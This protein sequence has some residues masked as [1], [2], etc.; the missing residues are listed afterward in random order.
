MS[1]ISAV[2]GGTT[3]RKLQLVAAIESR[4]AKYIFNDFIVMSFIVIRSKI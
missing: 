4:I 1:G 3:S 2:S